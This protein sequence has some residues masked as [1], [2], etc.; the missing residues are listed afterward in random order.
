MTATQAAATAPIT[1]ALLAEA[2]LRDLARQL[3]AAAEA[4]GTAREARKPL[5]QLA[6]VRGLEV[7]MYDAVLPRL[8]E[9][10][11]W[12]KQVTP[13]L[14]SR[15]EAAKAQAPK[16]AVVTT[17]P[18]PVTAPRVTQAVAPSAPKPP[19]TR[20]QAEVA[21]AAVVNAVAQAPKPAVVAPKP[22]PKATLN[23]N[24]TRVAAPAPVAKVATPTRQQLTNRVRAIDGLCHGL[25]NHAALRL[26][27]SSEAMTAH[28]ARWAATAADR[29]EQLAKVLRG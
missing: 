6:A 15:A 10:E 16:A 7:A 19:A 14:A 24:I 29:A 18:T 27:A 17:A 5:D 3:Y 26:N 20:P 22:A 11:S 23:T 4:L 2:A 13:V 25:P 8:A 1:T 12:A 21:K 28:I 9:V